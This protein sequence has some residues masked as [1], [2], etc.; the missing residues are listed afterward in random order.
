[1]GFR[2][3]SEEGGERNENGRLTVHP[4]RLIL[5]EQG[6]VRLPT[7]NR[8]F[9]FPLAVGNGH[10]GEANPIRMTGKRKK[11]ESGDNAFSVSSQ[12]GGEKSA[13]VDL[14]YVFH[15]Y[16]GGKGKSFNGMEAEG[17]K[18]RG[19]LRVRQETTWNSRKFKD[20]K[21]RKRGDVLDAK[22]NRD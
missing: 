11:E 9:P 15:S 20:R 2:H 21:G 10:Y 4:N 14:G 3:W 5:K 1:V 8:D 19:F 16:S 22:K 7:Y 13:R 18:R 17:E 6:V 12:V